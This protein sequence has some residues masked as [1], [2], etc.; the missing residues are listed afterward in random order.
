M[1]SLANYARPYTRS[2]FYDIRN[3]R[4]QTTP[5]LDE[6]SAMLAL[7]LAARPVPDA[8]KALPWGMRL[9]CA[10]ARCNT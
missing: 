10:I 2:H 3:N 4:S 5:N 1:R 7:G 6:G 8:D 9:P